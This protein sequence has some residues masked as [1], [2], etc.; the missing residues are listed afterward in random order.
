MCTRVE[1]EEV[2]VR[3]SS[4]WC[5]PPLQGKE[6]KYEFLIQYEYSSCTVRGAYLNRVKGTE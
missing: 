6:D 5:G 4:D 1:V 3:L 2:W